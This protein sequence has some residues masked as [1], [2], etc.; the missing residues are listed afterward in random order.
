LSLERIL[1]WVFSP[2]VWVMG[3]PLPDVTKVGTLLG[4]KMVL[5]EFVAYREMSQKLAETGGQWLSERGQ[6]IASYALCGF[7]NFGSVG[8][9]VGGYSGLCPERRGDL[10]RLGLRAMI[11]GTLATCLAAS[12]A[13]M[14]L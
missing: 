3:V 8:I 11:A 4:Q 14:L 9:Q 12:V 13:G 6:L 2:L 5:N 1:G 10:S 7:A